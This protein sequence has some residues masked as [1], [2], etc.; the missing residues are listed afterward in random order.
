M[1]K[2]QCLDREELDRMEKETQ[3]YENYVRDLQIRIRSLAPSL[4]GKKLCPEEEVREQIQRAEQQ[5]KIVRNK[6]REEYSALERTKEVRRQIQV[7]FEESSRTEKTRLALQDVYKRQLWG[8]WT[9][10]W[11]NCPSVGYRHF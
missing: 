1:Y 3:A 7:L 11:K 6:L 10:F 4:R 9:G 2:R 5:L 8:C